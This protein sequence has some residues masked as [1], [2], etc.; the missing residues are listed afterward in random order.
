M[1]MLERMIFE[2][3][4]TRIL[5]GITA[6]FGILLMVGWVAINEGGRMAAFEERSLARSIE[7]GAAL[8]ASGCAT[9]HGNDGRGITGRA[10]A[11]NNPQLFGYDFG[12]GEITAQIAKLEE[13]RDLRTQLPELE[14]ELAAETNPNVRQQL[15]EE[16]AAVQ[17]A[18]DPNFD[19]ID[20]DAEIVALQ[21]QYDEL[22]GQMQQA[23]ANGYDPAHPERLVNVGWAGDL[24]GFLFTTL[25]GGRPVS[26]SYW[27]Q[28]MPAWS[29][30]AGGPMRDDQLEDLVNYIMNWDRGEAWTLADLN[31]VQQF[32]VEPARSSGGGSEQ[33]A[34]ASPV[35]TNVRQIMGDLEGVEGD[36]ARGE[37]LFNSQETPLGGV[38]LGCSGC[39][40]GVV[41]PAAEGL[42]ARVETERLAD[43][44]L[45]GYTAEQ[46]VVESIVN[47]GAYVVEGYQPIMPGTFGE[48]LSTQDLADLLAYIHSLGE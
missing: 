13:Q 10:P 26:S 37:A 2:R 22:A 33:Q 8:F 4:E 18:I 47:P 23:I 29:Q 11:L 28:A 45:A 21:A 3:I 16:I 46:Y 31:A 19:G 43:A 1:L 7:R 27:P 24:Y 39:H 40:N 32:A 36:A 30:E 17:K 42:W 25:K 20:F 12:T 34:D 15:E 14:A 38:A 41:A 48:A 35:G 44:A 6:F 5:V 9:C